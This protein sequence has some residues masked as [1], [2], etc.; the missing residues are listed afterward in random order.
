MVL[1]CV[2]SRLAYRDWGGLKFTFKPV[3]HNSKLN[4]S[5]IHVIDC[6]NIEKITYLKLRQHL[7]NIFA[8]VLFFI[9]D[10][11]TLKVEVFKVFEVFLSKNVR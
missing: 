7:E 2:K 6:L 1:K 4:F 10:W 3:N 5:K 8:I 9:A 11:V